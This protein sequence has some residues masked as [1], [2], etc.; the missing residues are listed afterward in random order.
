MA[1]SSG[2]CH[3]NTSQESCGDTDLIPVPG[4]RGAKGVD[5]LLGAARTAHQW[6]T[7]ELTLKQPGLG[8]GVPHRTAG[9]K[10]SLRE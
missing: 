10:G 6:D 9:T 5:L 7:A 1:Q 3:H 2:V 4:S 8:A